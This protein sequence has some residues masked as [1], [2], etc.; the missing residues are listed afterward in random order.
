MKTNQVRIDLNDG[1]EVK[2]DFIQFDKIISDRG[3][4]YSVTGGRVTGKQGIEDFLK[5]LKSNK[6][7]AKATHHT[8]AARLSNDGQIWEIKTDDGETGAGGVVLRILQKKNLTNVI[9][10][11]TRWY[12]G[13]KLGPDRFKHV[14]DATVYWCN[15]V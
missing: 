8:W 11:V 12:G 14:Q 10:A 6:K 4:K 1:T 5:R 15:E 7:Y 13:K 9:V 3:S 2:K